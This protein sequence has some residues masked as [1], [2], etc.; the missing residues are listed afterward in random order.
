MSVAKLRIE[1][2]PNGLARYNKVWLN[3]EP[4]EQ[5]IK[6]MTISFGIGG[7]TI[8]TLNLMTT[9]EIKGMIVDVRESEHP[10]VFDKLGKVVANG[11]HD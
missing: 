11:N 4:I 5:Y 8:A 9:C 2:D 6:S 3:D 7:L 1:Q 10:I